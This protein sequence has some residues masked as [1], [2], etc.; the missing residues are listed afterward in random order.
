M[1]DVVQQNL[2]IH[3]VVGTVDTTGVVDKIRIAQTA[4]ERI[5]DPAQ[6]GHPQIA[7][8]ADDFRPYIATIH[9]QRV[10]GLVTYI[11]VLFL[12]GLDIGTDTTVP[13]QIDRR[14]EQCG[15]QLG[16]CHG[17]DAQIEPFLH[18]RRQAD[19]FCR[20]QENSTTGRNQFLLVIRPA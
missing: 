4:I 17:I 11:G 18:L 1:H 2:D 13:D 15:N 20:A 16:G 10:I 6:L 3:F 7:T 9:P 14:L 8:L 5:F 19:R 12:A